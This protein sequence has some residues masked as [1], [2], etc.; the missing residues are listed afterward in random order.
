MLSGVLFFPSCVAQCTLGVVDHSQG[1]FRG[2][3]FTP[4]FFIGWAL[5]IVPYIFCIRNIY[6]NCHSQRLRTF[7]SLLPATLAVFLCLVVFL[8]Q[9]TERSTFESIAGFELPDE[10]E[11]IGYS[12]SYEF[13][14]VDSKAFCLKIRPGATRKLIA[15]LNLKKGEVEQGEALP[16]CPDYK[17]WGVNN[18]WKRSGSTSGSIS[19]ISNSEYAYFWHTQH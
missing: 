13:F 19:L 3:S 2:L 17:D 6:K 5:L 10:A 14:G 4:L 9:P 7:W 11:I 18:S 1:F 16:N 8:F 15:K 12:E